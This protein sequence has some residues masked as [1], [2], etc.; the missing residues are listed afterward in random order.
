MKAGR[1]NM[2]RNELTHKCVCCGKTDVVEFDICPI[3]SWEDDGVQN[4]DPDFAGGANEM[5]LNEAKEA[6]RQGKPVY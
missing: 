4:D 6:Y 2:E 3:C 5:S 1:K